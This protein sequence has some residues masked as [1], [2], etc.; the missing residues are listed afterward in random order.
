M[1]RGGGKN[2]GNSYEI[3]I[4]RK[5]SEWLT[6]SQNPPVFWRSAS[7]GAPGTL[8]RRKG[9]KSN[10]MDGDIAGLTDEAVR[11]TNKVFFECKSYASWNIETLICPD[12]KNTISDWWKKLV[13]EAYEVNKIPVLIFK[14]NGST[15][16]VIV[17]D[18]FVEKLVGHGCK[19]LL[20]NCIRFDMTPDE[21][22]MGVSMYRLQDFLSSV[23]SSTLRL[24]LE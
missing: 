4:C 21:G 1:K 22:L 7:S 13:L 9:M 18:S 8:L 5:L 10:S 17:E 19:L 12:K 15:D 16:F 2:K 24:I 3:N 20:H 6:G 14:R 23:D 11:I